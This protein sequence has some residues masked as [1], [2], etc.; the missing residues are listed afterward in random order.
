MTM[1]KLGNV[2]YWLGCMAAVI[3]LATGAF[4]AATGAFDTLWHFLIV[5]LIAI[6][7]WLAAWVFRYFYAKV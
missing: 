7:I 5:V 3:A 4:E 2:V 1:V 6:V